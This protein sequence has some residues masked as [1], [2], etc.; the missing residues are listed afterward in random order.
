V[1]P[2]P[3]RLRRA[4]F[5]LPGLVLAALAAACG[6]NSSGPP[7]PT[8][9]IQ[10]T[11]TATGDAQTGPVT[12]ALTN[13]LRVVVT[14]NGAPQVGTSVTWASSAVGSSISPGGN[15]DMN[16]VATANWTLG[17]TAGTET[18]TASLS[19]ATG[20]PVTF[21]ATATPGPASQLSLV[22]GNN[23]S[24][25]PNSSLP[26]PLQVRVGD[27]FG[28]GVSGVTVSWL[29]TS[30]SAMVTPASGPTDATGTAQATVTLG[31]TAGSSTI[32]ATS[33]GLANSPQTFHATAMSL[34]MSANVTVGPGIVFTSVHNG[35]TTPATDTIA[36]G[37]TVTWTWAAGSILHSVES[38]GSPSFTSSTT[39]TSGTYSFTF[40]VA[41]NYS[42]DCA[43]HGSA[44]SGVIVV[45]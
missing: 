7:A 23:Q 5:L 1:K 2:I 9:T 10:K 35:T 22:S 13:P 41:G 44:M 3:V 34:P 33:A 26:N 8:P 45:K 6:G 25:A 20:S 31:A 27:Q 37:G 42:Y 24:G 12:T 19:G 32:T 40:N 15:T 38:V 14:L 28:N 43:V 18:A 21:T 36:V 17:Q 39:K 4:C 29:V 16:G 30:G 11:S